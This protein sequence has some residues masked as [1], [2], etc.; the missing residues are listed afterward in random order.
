MILIVMSQTKLLL[1][2][3]CCTVYPDTELA[4]VEGHSCAYGNS[5]QPR[6]NSRVAR[7]KTY[8]HFRLSIQ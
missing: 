6:D 8:F 5:I 2:I 1:L 7:R 4:E 3:C